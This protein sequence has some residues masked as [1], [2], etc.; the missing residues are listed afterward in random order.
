MP[1]PPHRLLTS[2]GLCCALLLV[3]NQLHAQDLLIV[4]ADGYFPPNEM[5]EQG[6]LRGVHIDLILAVSK[7]LNIKVQFRSYPWKRAMSLVQAGEAD[8]ITYMGKTAEREKFAYF[9]EGNRLSSTQNGFFTTQEN[10]S[11]IQ[12][13]GKLQALNNLTI[14]TIRGRAYFPEF[15]VASNLQKDD[16]AADEEQ[17]LKKMMAGRFDLALGHVSRIKYVAQQMKIADKLVFIQPYTPPI[18][19]YLAFSRAK[20]HQQLAQRFAQAMEEYKKS[21]AFQTLLRTY[22]VNPEDF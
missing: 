6:Q 19:N 7:Q 18:S 2:L 3:S 20:R 9:E 14:G 11:K 12:Y 1:K 21:P 13:A 8:A 5:V 17:L 22:Q 15:D 10:A 4:H 16:N